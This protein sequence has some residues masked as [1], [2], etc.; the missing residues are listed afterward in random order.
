MVMGALNPPDRVLE[1]EIWVQVPPLIFAKPGC[2]NPG[3]VKL[4]GDVTMSVTVVV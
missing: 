1:T 3:I 2:G 4:P